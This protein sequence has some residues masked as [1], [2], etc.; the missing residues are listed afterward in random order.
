MSDSRSSSGK[1]NH[2]HVTFNKIFIR[3]YDMTL[4]DNPSVSS[5]PPISLDL[6]YNPDTEILTIEDYESLRSQR[7]SRVQ[8]L[9][10]RDLREQILKVECGISR[11]QMASSIRTVKAVQANRR[12]TANNLKFAEA[13]ERAENVKKTLGRVV[14]VKKGR[15]DKEFEI[16]WEKTSHLD[17][18]HRESK[19]KSG[20]GEEWKPSRPFTPATS[21]VQ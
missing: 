12:Q 19:K 11:K 3:E 4:G 13:E 7:R 2:K 20:S 15:A 8:L 17:I 6:Y 14:G 21:K 10:P 5:G 1:E 9:V 16:L 18:R